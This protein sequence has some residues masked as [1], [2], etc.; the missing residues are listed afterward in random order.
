MVVLAGLSKLA[1][2][3]PDAADV[4]SVHLPVPRHAGGCYGVCFALFGRRGGSIPWLAA[5][6][7]HALAPLALVAAIVAREEEKPFKKTPS[8]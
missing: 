3:D 6:L 5:L 7:G 2:G 1:I 4:Q 8:G